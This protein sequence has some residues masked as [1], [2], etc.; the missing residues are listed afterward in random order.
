MRRLRRM[1]DDGTSMT[2]LL[3][4]MLISSI[5][6]IA[7]TSLTIGFERT[8]A[9]NVR[10]QDQVDAG[11]AAVERMTRNLRVAVRQSQMAASCAGCDDETFTSATP[12]RTV[13]HAAVVQQADGSF[14]PGLVTYE[15][16]AADGVLSE[17][18]VQPDTVAA[19]ASGW[20]YTCE[21]LPAR[22]S[23]A[24]AGKVST[25]RLAAGVLTDGPAL[26][27]YFDENSAALPATVPTDKLPHIASIELTVRVG[28]SG[29]AA[30]RPTT[31]VQ[32]VLLT[33][34]HAL[35][36]PNPGATP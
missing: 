5:V 20:T 28:S 9:E 4:V 1:R 15:I 30:P 11:R 7:T 21:N 26:F 6:V 35:L 12:F 25:R 29:S 3:V 10:R 33:N 27:T 31:Y 13:F 18:I 36:R 23:A 8:N 17:R 16:D 32:R 2:E 24:C 34:P 19:G 14:L 22:T